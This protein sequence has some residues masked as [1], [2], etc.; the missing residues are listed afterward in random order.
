MYL[1]ATQNL[2]QITRLVQLLHHVGVLQNRNKSVFS[3]RRRWAS[4]NAGVTCV[5]L[6][7][8][9]GQSTIGV[10]EMKRPLISCRVNDC[11]QLHFLPPPPSTSRS[12]R[13]GSS[14]PTPAVNQ[15]MSVYLLLSFVIRNRPHLIML[16]CSSGRA[17][18]VGA[19][20]APSAS[21]SF[22]HPFLCFCLG[23]LIDFQAP[24]SCRVPLRGPLCCS[25]SAVRTNSLPT[26]HYIL[27]IIIFY[28]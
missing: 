27:L 28:L 8:H 7:T 11:T 6:H 12:V 9:T 17:A 20:I 3:V 23:C 13:D 15:C 24:S 10:V 18:P 5:A 14:L 25:A 21:L 4:V 16:S 22:F 1:V 19:S 2:S 26:R